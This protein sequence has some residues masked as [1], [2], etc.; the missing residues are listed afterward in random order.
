MEIIIDD[1]LAASFVYY[2][3]HWV[4]ISFELSDEQ[5]LSVSKLCADCKAFANEHGIVVF[6]VK[7]GKNRKE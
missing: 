7:Y 4:L 5:A 3:L 6:P 2:G 1:P